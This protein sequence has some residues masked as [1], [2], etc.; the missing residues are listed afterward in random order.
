MKLQIMDIDLSKCRA[1]NGNLGKVLET[2]SKSSPALRTVWRRH[3]CGFSITYLRRKFYHD[4]GKEIP[5]SHTWH[6]VRHQEFYCSVYID[7]TKD[8]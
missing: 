3:E 2:M 8:F 1:G 6:A 4:K 5:G 7:K